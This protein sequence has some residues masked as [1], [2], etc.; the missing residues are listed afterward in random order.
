MYTLPSI[1]IITV[2][3]PITVSRMRDLAHKA[4][5]TVRKLTRMIR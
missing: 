3:E 1:A 2:N 5:W 4:E